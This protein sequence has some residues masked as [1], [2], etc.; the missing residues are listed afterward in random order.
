MG[1]FSIWHF[2]VVLILLGATFVGASLI[3]LAIRFFQRRKR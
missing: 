2:A 3:Y 1:S